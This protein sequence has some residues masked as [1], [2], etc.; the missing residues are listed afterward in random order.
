MAAGMQRHVAEIIT[1]LVERVGSQGKL[2]KRLKI[3][4][5]SISRFVS[6][7]QE[8]KLSQWMRITALYAELKGWRLIDDRLMH[9]DEQTRQLVYEIVETI[10]R[11]RHVR[12][13]H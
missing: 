11:D 12:R 10:L 5:A 1:E 7:A 8:P 6:G 4:Q 2:A 13:P 9:E 3:S